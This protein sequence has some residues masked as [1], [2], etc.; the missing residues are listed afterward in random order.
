[1]IGHLPRVL[2]CVLPDYTCIKEEEG[3][4]MPVI[5]HFK[6]FRIHPEGSWKLTWAI[7]MTWAILS[8]KRNNQNNEPLGCFTDYKVFSNTILSIFT[9]ENYDMSRLAVVVT[10]TISK[11]GEVDWFRELLQVTQ[12]SQDSQEL[13]HH[14]LCT[15]PYLRCL[16]P[17][18][19]Q[20]DAL[21]WALSL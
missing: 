21:C 14:A 12:L 18:V 2:H 8:K 20:L 6:Q 9:V 13:S 4:K 7:T 5:V 17:T 3:D 15:F 10:T 19:P 16:S 11:W 1:M